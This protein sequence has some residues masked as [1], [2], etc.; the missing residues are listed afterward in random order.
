MNKK[1]TKIFIVAIM[2]LII[3]V[4]IVIY[5]FNIKIHKEIKATKEFLQV[6]YDNKM[7]KTDISINDIEFN[8]SKLSDGNKK[9]YRVTSKMYGLDLDAD[10]NVVAFNNYSDIAAIKDNSITEEAAIVL[11][12]EYIGKIVK[13]DYKYKEKISDG[14]DS[15]SYYGYIFTR[16]KDGYPFYSDQIMIQIDKY[17]GYLTA[18][19]NTATQCIPKRIDV[20]IKIDS[21]EAI[22]VENFNNSSTNKEGSIEKDTTYIAYCDNSDK[23]VTKLCYI[24]VVKGLD[25]DNNEI[26]WKYFITADTGEVLNSM[27]DTVS[28]TTVQE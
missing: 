9:Y 2:L 7:L 22:A 24:V 23:T 8:I 10:Y 12:E 26:K 17:S 15:L 20:K 5:L 4:G 25:I 14:E 27:K 13:E 6:L 21:A 1:G 11:A 28:K 19:T 18:Y 16:Y 3:C